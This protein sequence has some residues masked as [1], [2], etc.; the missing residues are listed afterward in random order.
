MTYLVSHPQIDILAEVI[1]PDSRHA[2]T[3]YLDYL[4]RNGIIQWE[5]RQTVRRAVMT[6]R[7]NPGEFQ[8][9]VQLRYSQSNGIP[10]REI[11][12]P[13]ADWV[14]EE[15]E[16]QI[17]VQQTESPLKKA[18]MTPFMGSKQYQGPRT[19]KEHVEQEASKTD[20]FGNMRIV[21]MSREKA[22]GFGNKL[23]PI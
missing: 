9:D 13:E 15:Q 4:S 3:T 19:I 16:D 14:T 17:E 7:V 18:V 10:E 2:R 23:R 22:K 1:A 21:Q 5:Q 12:T 20:L 11:G 8:S 6:K